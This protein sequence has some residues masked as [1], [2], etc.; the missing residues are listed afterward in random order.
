M[1]VKSRKICGGLPRIKNT[2]ITVESVLFTLSQGFSVDDIKKIHEEIG[3]P[4]QRKDLLEA[5]EYGSTHLKH[6][7]E[8][9]K[10]T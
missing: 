8:K 9:E 1:I 7:D 10:K 3:T 4:L 6:H 2:R 5:L